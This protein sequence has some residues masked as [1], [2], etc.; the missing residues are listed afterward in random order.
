MVAAQAAADPVI[1]KNAQGKEFY[2]V[3]VLLSE[4]AVV[5]VRVK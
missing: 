2:E 3:Y 4:V 1:V 5:E